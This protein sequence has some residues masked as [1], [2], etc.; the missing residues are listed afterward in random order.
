MEEDERRTEWA[1]K[2]GHLLRDFWCDDSLKVMERLFCFRPFLSRTEL[3]TQVLS[4]TLV[5]ITRLS[6]PR[7]LLCLVSCCYP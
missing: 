3:A 4:S 7:R 2:C 5:I 6:F 1:A